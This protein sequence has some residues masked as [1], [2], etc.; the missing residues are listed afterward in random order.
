MSASPLITINVKN[1]TV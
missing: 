1:L